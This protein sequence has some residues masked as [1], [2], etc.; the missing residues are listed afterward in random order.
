MNT[1]G[2]CDFANDNTEGT[3]PA[4]LE[5]ITAS[6][7]PLEI[8]AV[9]K[10]RSR[11]LFDVESILPAPL[12]N[13]TALPAPLEINAIIKLL[14]RLLFDVEIIL[15]A[16]LEIITALPAPLEINAIIKLLSRLLLFDVESIL[17]KACGGSRCGVVSVY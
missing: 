7:A 12:E 2:S 8:D 3:L 10:L 16:P 11:L 6:P 17:L 1:L 15:P 4:P 5:N 14:S 9:I 13:I